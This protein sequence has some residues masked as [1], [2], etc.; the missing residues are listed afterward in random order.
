MKEHNQLQSVNFERKEE[1][2]LN[3]EHTGLEPA[4]I[5]APDT[6][7]CE[8]NFNE[9]SRY[10]LLHHC[11]LSFATVDLCLNFVVKSPQS[12]LQLE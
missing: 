7:I 10:H 5:D 2:H 12:G 8:N 11:H 6:V 3:M 1:S 9:I 4:G